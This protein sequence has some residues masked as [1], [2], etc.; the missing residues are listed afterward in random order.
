MWKQQ[1]RTYFERY[2]GLRPQTCGQR[3]IGVRLYSMTKRGNC[4]YIE[5]NKSKKRIKEKHVYK[6]LQ[7]A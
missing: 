3:F 5:K 7:R 4:G 6:L 2:R 1:K